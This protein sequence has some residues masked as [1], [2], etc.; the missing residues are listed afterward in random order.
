MLKDN[1]KL[2]TPHEFAKTVG[3]TKRALRYYDEQGILKPVYIND[4]GH[5]FYS[6]KSFFEAQ[7]IL[8]LKFLM[9]SLDEI[10]E[11][12]KNHG[13]IKESLTMQRNMLKEKDDQIRS[14]IKTIDDMEN[15]IDQ[16]SEIAW[17]DIFNTVKFAKYQMV[18]ENM[19]DYYDAR[20]EEYDE[21]Y[22]GKGPASFPPDYYKADI[23]SLHIF[24]KEFGKGNL[25]DIACGSGYWLKDYY[26]KCSHFT[27]LD[28]STRM[29]QQCKIRAEEYG[30]ADRAT[31]IR[32]DILSYEWNEEAVFDSAV[33][34]FLLGHFTKLQEDLFF[35][36]L[37]KILK[38]GSEILIIENTWTDKRAKKQNKEDI[39]QRQLKDGRNYKIYK[40]YYEKDDL[41]KLLQQYHFK[42]KDNFFG[43]SFTAVIGEVEA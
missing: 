23:E 30:I 27:F 8:S 39:A 16:S 4:A 41:P 7:R 10:R 33:I 2:Y 9:F 6:K 26:Q 3:L 42:V 1:E 12:Q 28:Q 43:K 13:N 34:G 35:G 25:I 24:T 40:K 38:P 15:A 21:I 32:R 17:E 29:L 36:T 5:K 20:A 19:M 14:I 37:R 22:E 18:H 11:I 31:F